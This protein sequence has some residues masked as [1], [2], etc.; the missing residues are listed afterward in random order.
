MP[1]LHSILA[2]DVLI[3]ADFKS[4]LTP[5]FTMGCNP[6]TTWCR[7]GQERIMYA[8]PLLRRLS[9]WSYDNLMCKANKV[10]STWDANGTYIAPLS[11][12]LLTSLWERTDFHDVISHNNYLNTPWRLLEIVTTREKSLFK[13]CLNLKYV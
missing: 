8:F 2:P 13:V 7:M 5:C 6:S 4:V 9:Y 12:F 3:Q 1:P 10:V 11:M